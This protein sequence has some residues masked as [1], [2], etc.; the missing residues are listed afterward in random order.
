MC[1]THFIRLLTILPT[2]QA[3]VPTSS[4]LSFSFS[5]LFTLAVLLIHLLSHTYSLL[6]LIRF[7]AG[8][9]PEND[10]KDNMYR[11]SSVEELSD[12]IPELFNVLT[13]EEDPYLRWTTYTYP[14]HLDLLYF[15][16]RGADLD[17]STDM[18]ESSYVC[19]ILASDALVQVPIRSS[20]TYDSV[21][22]YFAR[23]FC[24][25]PNVHYKCFDT[26]CS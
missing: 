24:G 3:F 9:C 13:E 14:A 11:T 21:F 20:R 8:M 18:G 6:L 7:R 26:L 1:P 19:L 22:I 15:K 10:L 17:P 23:G 12:P 4:H 5:N 16:P 25:F 2:I